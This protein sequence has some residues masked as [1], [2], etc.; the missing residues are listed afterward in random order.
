[1]RKT[2]LNA[3]IAHR[4]TIADRRQKRALARAN[5]SLRARPEQRLTVPLP[6]QRLTVP[7][8]ERRPTAQRLEQHQTGQPPEQMRT[9]RAEV[10][11]LQPADL[12]PPLQKLNLQ[13]RVESA[14]SCP[15]CWI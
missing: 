4:A 6:E 14:P 5:L 12:A 9:S 10:Q 3:T 7:L 11:R 8:P 13:N 15:A 1:M 2:P